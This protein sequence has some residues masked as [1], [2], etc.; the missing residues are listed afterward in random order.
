MFV[1]LG[2]AATEG[3]VLTLFLAPCV[4][5]SVAGSNCGGSSAVD[6]E[7][8]R[9]ACVH[10]TSG[11]FWKSYLS[12]DTSSLCRIYPQRVLSDKTVNTPD[13]RDMF[14]ASA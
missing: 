13:K 1:F 5:R 12:W 14:K 10:I 3:A 2:E 9:R 11:F 8:V 4:F 7:Y 6:E